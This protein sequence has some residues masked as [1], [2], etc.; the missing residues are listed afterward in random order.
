MHSI[1]SALHSPR[2][3]A[4]AVLG[5]GGIAT[6]LINFPG[7][8]EDDSFAQLLEGRTGSYSFWHP[9]V[10]S[11]LLGLSDALPGPAAGWF[12]LLEMLLA[13]GALIGVLWM[14]RRVSWATAAAAG[15]MLF[16]PQLLMLQAVV[17]KDALFANA[18]VGAF[19]CLGL[20]AEHWRRVRLRF[21]M[22]G[23]SV[24]LLCLAVLTR[25][26]GFVILPFAVVGLWIVAAKREGSGRTGAVYG[27]ALLAASSLLGWGAHEFFMTRWDGTPAREQQ[28]KILWLYDITGMVR[29]EPEIG[30]GSL[31]RDDPHLRQV[32]LDEGVRRWSPVKNDTL[33]VSPRIVAALD[34]AP[35][36]ALWNQWFELVVS[37]PGNYL[38][39]R[40]ELFWWVFQS[41]DVGQCHPFHV[42]DEG[43]PDEMK[44]LGAV[45]RLDARDKALWRYGDVFEYTPAFWHGAYAAIALVVLVLVLKR[46]RPG[47][48]AMASLIGATGAFTGTFF[49]ISIACDYRYLYVI[50]LTALAGVLYVTCEWR[51]FRSLF[52]KKRGPEGPLVKTK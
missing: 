50:D 2:I 25:Q 19:V 29:R 46:R 43:D 1:K 4:A 12:V 23:L 38:A 41:P 21:A 37:H 36:F 47:D 26:N 30:L 51:E 39:V 34:A 22:L 16:L 15:V 42:G 24:V 11:W 45:T 49:V 5:L 9:P 10:M 8:M 14:A 48:I 6:Y 31:E 33:E 18:C 7:S 28:V 52:E 13:F 35:W 32:I 3:V 44:E 27:A 40:G 20:A 17:W